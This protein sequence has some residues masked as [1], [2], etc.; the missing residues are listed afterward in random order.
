MSYLFRSI[1]G[2]NG[3]SITSAIFQSIV[4]NILTAKI[5]GPNAEE[6]NSSTP[7]KMRILI[8]DFPYIVY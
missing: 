1:G 4:K 3:I 2:V 8:S 5:T 6:V 7:K